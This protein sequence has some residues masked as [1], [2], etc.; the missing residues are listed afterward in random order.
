EASR[1]KV[2]IETETHVSDGPTLAA[3]FTHLGYAPAFTY[4]K[5][6]TEWSRSD[7]PSGHV[8]VDETPIG[9]Y[10]ELEGPTTWID[11]ILAELA[12]DPAT[13]L[14]DSYGKLFLEWKQRT[15]SSAENLTFAE[16][17]APVLV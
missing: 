4:E 1:Y 7:E 6:R 17:S 8:V 13:C 16:I 2:R 10:A 15:G 11:R 9:T 5:Y 3:I 12:I 14:T